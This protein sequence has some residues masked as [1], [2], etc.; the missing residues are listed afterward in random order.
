MSFIDVDPQIVAYLKSERIAALL[1]H[2]GSVESISDGIV[3]I[4][5]L[6]DVANGEVIG[7]S[8]KGELFKV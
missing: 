8:V 6:S 3:S 4:K 2:I 1:H 7:F 5:G